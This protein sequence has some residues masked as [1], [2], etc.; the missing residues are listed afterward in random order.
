[1]N[2]HVEPIAI[3]GMGARLP[4]AVDVDQYWK[5]LC[6]GRESISFLSDDELL[7]NG[8]TPERLSDTDYVKA[9][10][11]VPEVKTFDADLFGMTA[12]EAEICDPALRLFLEVSHAAIENSGYDVGKVGEGFGVF[13]SSGAC[14]Y[15]EHY[16]RQ[17][18]KYRS[19]DDFQL[20][21]LNNTD[22]VST[23]TAYKLNLR[24]PAMTIVTACSSSAVALHVACQ[25]LRYGECDAAVVGG[26]HVESPYGHGH[27]WVPGGILTSDGHCRPFS[28]NATGTIFGSGCACSAAASRPAMVSATS[29]VQINW[30]VRITNLWA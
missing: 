17:S 30:S 18:L 8:V 2:D 10:P 26:A 29:K 4:G 11:L 15:Q 13:A 16:L 3:I 25:S 19:A 5:N 6:D 27:I 24:G 22:Y 9:T 12:R 28:A 7:A 20:G 1:M 23:L 21:T 14:D